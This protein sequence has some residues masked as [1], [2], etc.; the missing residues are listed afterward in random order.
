MEDY[1]D[2]RKFYME[3]AW[4]RR[5]EFRRQQLKFMRRYMNEK[6]HVKDHLYKFEP[7]A[8]QESEQEES[9]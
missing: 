5:T 7:N 2:A 3:R 9:I 6:A 1:P 4:Q 8:P